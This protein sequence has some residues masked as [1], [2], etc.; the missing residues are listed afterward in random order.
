MTHKTILVDTHFCLLGYNYVFCGV[1][2]QLS[3]QCNHTSLESICQGAR[4]HEVPGTVERWMWRLLV[5]KRVVAEW[6]QLGR[7]V[8]VGKGSPQGGGVLSPTMWCL[9]ADKLLRLL[10]EARFFTRAYA[11]VVIIVYCGQSGDCW[12][13]H[14]VR[15][16]HSGE[17]VQ[18]SAANGQSREG[19]GCPFHQEVQDLAYVGSDAVR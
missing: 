16:I 10:S 1:R 7:E 11:D 14:K 2:M 13:P 15:A 18:R 19:R 4:E 3:S 6:K 5:S 9:V 17:I 8:W 12:G